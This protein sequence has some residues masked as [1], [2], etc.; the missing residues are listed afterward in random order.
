MTGGFSDSP[1][2]DEVAGLLGPP[3][4]TAPFRHAGGEP[5]YGC[6]SCLAE[7]YDIDNDP[8]DLL[9]REDGGTR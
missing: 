8:D 9:W 3:Q 2:F 5:C 6:Q 4:R 7:A 1:I